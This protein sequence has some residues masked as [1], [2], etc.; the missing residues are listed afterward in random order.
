MHTATTTFVKEGVVQVLVKQLFIPKSSIASKKEKGA[1]VKYSKKPEEA[2]L[3]LFTDSILVLK[4][5]KNK[6]SKKKKAIELY[7]NK[8]L[9]RI[10]LATSRFIVVSDATSQKVLQFIHEGLSYAFLFDNERTWRDWQKKIKVQ[11]KESMK[12]KIQK[13]NDHPDPPKCKRCE[14]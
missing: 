6:N 3:Y 2:L 9:V 5:K 10:P 13:D 14:C 7:D 1:K 8:L 4:R 12:K 11:V